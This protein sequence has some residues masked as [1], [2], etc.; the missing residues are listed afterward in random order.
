MG[1]VRDRCIEGA[2]AGMKFGQRLRSGSGLPDQGPA[3]GTTPIDPSNP[4]ALGR[5]LTAMRRKWGEDGH[6]LDEQERR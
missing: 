5:F 3:V 2:A 6:S 4:N 1:P